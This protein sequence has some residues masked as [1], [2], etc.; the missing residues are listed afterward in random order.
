[1]HVGLHGMDHES[2]RG[3][4]EPRL[5]REINE[6]Q[7]VIASACGAPVREAACPFGAYDR[8]VLAFLRTSGMERVYTS[9]R[10]LARRDAW[11]Q[12]RNTIRRWDDTDAITRIVHARGFS[13]LHIARRLAKRWR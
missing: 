4:D 11:L 12:A 2:W 6:A 10:G 13:V 5:R 3:L 9:D 8:R 1:M 7:R